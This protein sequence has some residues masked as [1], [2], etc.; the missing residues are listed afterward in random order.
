MGKLTMNGKDIT[1]PFTYN[2]KKVV[3]LTMNGKVLTLKSEI[4][5]NINDY[6]ATTKDVKY[7]AAVHSLMIVDV[8]S[9]QTLRTITLG[10]GQEITFTG[11]ASTQTEGGATGKPYQISIRV[12]NW[13]SDRT[14]FDIEISKQEGNAGVEMGAGFGTG[15]DLEI[16]AGG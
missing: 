13:S 6:L 7:N 3:S 14:H 9:G 8:D 10:A 1:K 12:H 11:Y 16:K 5:Y 15:L 4:V 2:G